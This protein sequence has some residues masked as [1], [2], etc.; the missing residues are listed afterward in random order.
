MRDFAAALPAGGAQQFTC[1]GSFGTNVHCVG[2]S[3]SLTPLPLGPVVSSPP[4]KVNRP[5]QLVLG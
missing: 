2:P 3:C 1:A 4:E 5:A